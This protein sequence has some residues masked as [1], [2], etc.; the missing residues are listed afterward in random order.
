MIG[1]QWY[2]ATGALLLGVVFAKIDNSIGRYTRKLHRQYG[3]ILGCAIILMLTVYVSKVYSNCIW[4][5]DGATIVAVMAFCAM[6][7][8]VAM[9]FDERRSLRVL[10]PVTMCGKMSLWLYVIH[11]KVMAV[12]GYYFNSYLVIFLVVSFAGAYLLYF[13]NDHVLKVQKKYVDGR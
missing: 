7:F 12:L 9:L 13:V 6:L 10:K 8:F 1:S 11:M 4:L 3:I 2:T 5:K